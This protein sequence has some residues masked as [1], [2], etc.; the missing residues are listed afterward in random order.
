M[1]TFFRISSFYFF[2]MIFQK[3]VFLGTYT[4][5]VELHIPKV[6][7]PSL[8]VW[9]VEADGYIDLYFLNNT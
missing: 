8:L 5:E 6:V 3:S 9:F 7:M 2:M 1:L 4:F